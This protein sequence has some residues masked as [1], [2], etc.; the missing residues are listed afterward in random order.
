[1]VV[2]L[3][4]SPEVAK[5]VAVDMLMMIML[6]MELF[7]DVVVLRAQLLLLLLLLLLPPLPLLVIE[8]VQ[9]GIVLVV[10]ILALVASFNYIRMNASMSLVKFQFLLCKKNEPKLLLQDKF[11]DLIL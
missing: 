5:L 7:R 2:V 9:V 11:F 10:L 4:V 1:M 3:V 6:A 8:V